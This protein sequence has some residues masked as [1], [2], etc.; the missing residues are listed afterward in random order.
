ML[1]TPLTKQLQIQHPILQGGMAWLATSELV[2]AVS[3]A[4]G[5]GIL[6]AGNAP[7]DWVADQNAWTRARL[8][9]E[10]SRSF[11]RD[12]LVELL[13]LPVVQQVQPR[14]ST[15]VLLE[16]A[17]RPL[18]RDQLLDLTKG[19]EADPFDRSIDNAVLRLRKKL[20]TE[21]ER[22]RESRKAS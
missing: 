4:G 12:R 6:G 3:R 14:G 18:S 1:Q 21:S 22:K 15:L 8:D 20:L 7:T 2:I 11:W 10:P 16:R 13:G 19:R 9:G 5:L 17:G